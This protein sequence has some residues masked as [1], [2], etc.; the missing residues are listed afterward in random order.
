MFH[1]NTRGWVGFGVRKILNFPGKIFK[2]GVNPEGRGKL[3]GT[4]NI[5]ISIISLREG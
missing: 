3:L 4:K 5:E 2:E 1:E